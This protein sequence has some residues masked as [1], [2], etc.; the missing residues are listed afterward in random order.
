MDG[1]SKDK[2]LFFSDLLTSCL[3]NLNCCCCFCFSCWCSFHRWFTICFPLTII[4]FTAT[5]TAVA[6]STIRILPPFQ[7]YVRSWEPTKP[8]QSLS[9]PPLLVIV[10]TIKITFSPWSLNSI[11]ISLSLRKIFWIFIL[12]VTQLRQWTGK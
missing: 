12:A 3:L 11:Y 9:I 4:S 6:N 1:E 7:N 8:F 10:E 2:N 5:A